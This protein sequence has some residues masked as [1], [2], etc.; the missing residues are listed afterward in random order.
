MRC[1]D[2]S[3]ATG[4]HIGCLL[5]VVVI[6]LD[7][8]VVRSCACCRLACRMAFAFAFSA[9]LGG[10]RLYAWMRDAVGPCCPWYRDPS[11]GDP[12]GNSQGDES[13]RNESWPIFMPGLSAIGILATFESSSVTS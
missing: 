1:F 9:L 6:G 7:G 3:G 2:W 11:L 5:L 4:R 13:R 8:A 10:C 12:Y